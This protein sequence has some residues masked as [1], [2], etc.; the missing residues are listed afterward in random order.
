M[1]L[2]TMELLERVYEGLQAQNQEL[3]QEIDRIVTA[4]GSLALGAEGDS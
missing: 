3:R 2:T 1:A 4:H